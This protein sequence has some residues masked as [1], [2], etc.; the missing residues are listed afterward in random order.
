MVLTF[1][2]AF[3]I[4]KILDLILGD[5]VV[6]YDRKRLMELIKMTTRNEEGLAEELKIAVGAMEISDKTVADVM[7]K[8]ADVFMLPDTTVLNTKTVAEILRMGKVSQR[9]NQNA[10]SQK[11]STLL[12]VLCTEEFFSL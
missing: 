4:S 8:I 10:T 7:T 1:P 3:P 11:V 2:L 5:E 12:A 6:S 9:T